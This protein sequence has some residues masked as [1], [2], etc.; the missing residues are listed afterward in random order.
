[1]AGRYSKGS[2]P[3]CP[4]MGHAV[5]HWGT[6]GNS[7]GTPAAPGDESS[8]P[9]G[10]Y[11][12]GSDFSRDGIELFPEDI[13][14]GSGSGLEGDFADVVCHGPLFPGQPPTS[15]RCLVRMAPRNSVPASREKPG[16]AAY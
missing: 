13:P 16:P 12:Q 2:S 5:R 4:F 9:S 8:V 7:I 15:M 11:G 10:G 6:C 14:A 1:M 3:P